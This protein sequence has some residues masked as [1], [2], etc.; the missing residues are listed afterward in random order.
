MRKN[1]QYDEDMKKPLHGQSNDKA[2][3]IRE[4]WHLLNQ[5]LL[6]NE[7]FSPPPVSS[8][9]AARKEYYKLTPIEALIGSPGLKCIFGVITEIQ[10]GQYY[11]EDCNSYVPVDIKNAEVTA[12]LFTENCFVLAEGE[13]M[14]GV[15][16]VH[17][18][19]KLLFG[20]FKILYH[21]YL[22]F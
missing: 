17:A 9:P 15:F 21:H 16:V 19:G 2:L 13:L 18:L 3:M 8:G 6:R 11:I 14:D 20:L 10:E 5:R 1:F 12:G 7:L 4:R 22:Y